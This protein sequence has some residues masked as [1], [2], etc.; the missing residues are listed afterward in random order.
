MCWAAAS[1]PKGAKD[2]T[3]PE[4]DSRARAGPATL[5]RMLRRITSLQERA[6]DAGLLRA[7]VNGRSTNTA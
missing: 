6:L 1:L 7:Y 5:S 3:R 2:H 4:W